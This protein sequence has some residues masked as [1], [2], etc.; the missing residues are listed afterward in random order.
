MTI[1]ANRLIKLLKQA[2]AIEIGAFHA[3]SGHWRSLPVGSIER[4]Q[5]HLIQFDELAHKLKLEV[6]LES[7]DAQPSRFQDAILW[8]IGKTISVGCHI[9]GYKAAMW[10]A[11]IM[12]IMGS[13]VYFNLAR[14]AARVGDR[15][16]SNYLYDMGVQEEEH[17]EFFKK[18]LEQSK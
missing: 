18:C 17:E 4:V 10:G 11:K 14:E 3:Y 1:G 6:M 9:F 7:L 13:N 2:H 8:C 12:E 5:V 15:E 16:M